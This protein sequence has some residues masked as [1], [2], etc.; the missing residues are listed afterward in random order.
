[1]IGSLDDQ[2]K[3]RL[4]VLP[5]IQRAREFRLYG[6]DGSRWLDCWLD[7]GRALLGHRPDGLSLRLKNEIARGLY[8][9]YPGVWEG[10]L[11]RAL[12]RFRPGFSDWRIY[13]SPRIAVEKLGISN[14]PADP[15]DDTDTPALE[16]LWGRPFLD[17]GPETRCLFPHLPLPGLTRAQVV[18]FRD[19][20]MSAPPSDAI[21]PVI[22]SALARIVDEVI[23]AEKTA[24]NNADLWKLPFSADI[25]DRRG[26]Y[27]T[28]RGDE[29]A[30]DALFDGFASRNVLIAPSRRRP[31]VIPPIL[32]PYEWDQLTKG[33]G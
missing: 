28:F 6:R 30:Y 24:Q 23:K 16:V 31:T 21:S 18:L 7:D 14:G 8:A 3:A 27:I 2:E 32:S 33:A 5:D 29:N 20:D 11:G 12:R 22:L 1:M 4:Q 15:L 17:T 25:W 13:E 26:P 9:P 10:R 19:S